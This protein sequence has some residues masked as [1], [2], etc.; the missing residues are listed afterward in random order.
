MCIYV[1][2]EPI[3]TMRKVGSFSGPPGLS[4]T[5]RPLLRLY[6]DILINVI[7]KFSIITPH[8]TNIQ[9]TLHIPVVLFDDT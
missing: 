9:A 6:A 3:Y 5:D 7:S 4:H 8:M 2:T 1:Y